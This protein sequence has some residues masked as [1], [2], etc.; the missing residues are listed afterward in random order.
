MIMM[1]M[2]TVTVMVMVTVMMVRNSDCR[3]QRESS[4][5]HV[6]KAGRA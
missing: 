4:H 2:V 1:V 6:A 3:V 5:L